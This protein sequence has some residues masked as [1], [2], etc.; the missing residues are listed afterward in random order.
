MDSAGNIYIADTGNATIRVINTQ[1]TPQT[2]FQYTVQPGFMR[3]I[4]NCNSSLTTPCP[5]GTITQTA[6]TGINGPGNAAVFQSQYKEAE[7]DAYGNLY[8]LNGTGGGTGP[9]GIYANVVYAGGA[10]LTNLLVAETPTLSSTYPTPPELNSSGLPTYGNA[11]ISIG[12][13]ALTSTLPGAT[14]GFPDVISTQNEQFDIRPSSLLPDNFGT[15]WFYDNHF[16]EV[17]RIDQYS[18]LATQTIKQGRAT[19]SVTGIYS[20][21]ATF[22]N[23][24]YCVYGASGSAPL[25]WGQGPQSFDPQGDGCPSVVAFFSGGNA[26]VSDG[27]G[28]IFVGDGFENLEREITVGTGFPATA[29]GTATGV[30]QP[31]QVHF[32]ANNPPVVGA[33]IPDSF[34][35]GNTTTSITIA[36]GSIP[37]FT[38]DTTDPEF[39][40]GSLI[41]GSNSA[42]GN[43]IKTTNFAMWA[44]LPT[45]AAL[46]SYPTATSD[47]SLDCLVY[48][49]F[50]PTAPGTRQSQLLVTTAN[51]S[52]YTFGLTGVGTGGQLTIDGG[53]A[54]VVPATGLGNTAGIAVAQSGTIY[55]AD[56]SNNRI[57][58]E[59]GGTQSNLAFTGV[60]P[61]TLNGPMGVALDSA[62]NVYISDTG[63]NRIL[64]VNPL[65]GVATAL[66]NYVWVPGA[67]CDGKSPTSPTCPAGGIAS[68]PGASVTPT[69]APPQ[70]AFKNPQGLAVDA[71]NNVYVADTG[72]SAVVEIPPISR[73]AER[74]LSSTTLAR[75]SSR[76]RW[77]LLS[78]RKAISTLRTPRLPVPWLW[79]C[80]PAAGTW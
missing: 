57:V 71:S 9:P 38:I 31:I 7:V 26:I 10:P 66:G 6:N 29:V 70:Y 14:T 41:T 46:G 19:A 60:T 52:K 40:F 63:N 49:T 25:P 65:T 12:N 76:T 15:L 47:T 18:E 45:C 22:S 13:P 8:Q 74:F 69:T 30:T 77:R 21:P 37:D 75:R 62:G 4:S 58:I 73:W 44:G 33:S 16:P 5:S 35:T 24:W 2:F 67:T 50:K 54:T 48:V 51:G 79:S 55:I 61:A 72:N 59:N 11:Y 20:G 80:R 53:G 27:V 17:N 23:P 78:I 43:N 36:P 1:A 32:G 56:P 34:M 39:P 68:E 42:Y 64:K 28:N 3:S